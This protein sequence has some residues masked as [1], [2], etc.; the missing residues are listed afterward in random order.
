MRLGARHPKAVPAWGG[1]PQGFAD[2]IGRSLA[3]VWSILGKTRSFVPSASMHAACRGVS[4]RSLGP[5]PQRTL[6]TCVKMIRL[7][8]GVQ[9]GWVARVSFWPWKVSWVSSEP[10]D[11]DGIQVGGLVGV[12]PLAQVV[13]AEHDLVVRRM[14]V[15]VAREHVPAGQE[16]QGR[17][18]VTADIRDRDG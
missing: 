8:S 6:P 9:V 2:G 13:G 12:L 18:A 14:P 16:A 7:P 10:S 4:S 3:C 1:L 5:P 17:Q 15:R 11:S